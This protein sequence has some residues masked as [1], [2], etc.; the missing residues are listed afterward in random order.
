[1]GGTRFSLTM[2]IIG[3][4][5]GT[6]KLFMRCVC[7]IFILWLAHILWFCPKYQR[8]RANQPNFATVC[9]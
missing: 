6:L 5:I 3:R 9:L 8:E 2:P 4:D 1:M 7:D